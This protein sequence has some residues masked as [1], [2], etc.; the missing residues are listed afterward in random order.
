MEE[1]CLD[2]YGERLKIGD[3]VIPV[4]GIPL[5]MDMKGSITDIK[6]SGHYNTSY[7]TVYDKDN[8]KILHDV[9]SKY[10]T[11]KNRLEEREIKNCI[12]KL[13]FYD[14]NLS[15]IKTCPLTGHTDI[16]YEIPENTCLVTLSSMHPHIGN[17]P[18]YLTADIFNLI[19]AGEFRIRHRSEYQCYHLTSER[20]GIY[21]NDDFKM[22]NSLDELKNYLK[23]LIVFFNTEDIQTVNE[24][25]LFNENSA[26]QEYDEVLVH[27][28]KHL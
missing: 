12:Y 26:Y 2:V 24:P 14:S 27:R 19:L 18:A 10:F 28:L 5:M 13:E 25:E 21:I 1:N 17:E 23:S 3:E 9:D 16:N 11:L 7:I 20:A 22:F 6:Y 15:Q 8:N 4:I